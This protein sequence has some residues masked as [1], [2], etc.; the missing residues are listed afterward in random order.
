MELR[1]T[2]VKSIRVQALGGFS[3]NFYWS[4][5]G[6]GVVEEEKT[7]HASCIEILV[8]DCHSLICQNIMYRVSQNR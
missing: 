4:F 1:I 6:R 8:V 5:I 7:V 3:Q 2:A